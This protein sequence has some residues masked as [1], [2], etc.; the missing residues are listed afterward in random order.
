MTPTPAIDP[1]REALR[2]GI[3]LFNRGEYY[4]AHEVLEGPWRLAK[5]AERDLY[6]GLIK[7]AAALHH[8]SRE[9]WRSAFLLLRRAIIQLGPHEARTAPVPLGEV[10]PTMESNLEALERCD[11]GEGTFDLASVDPL[12]DVRA[13]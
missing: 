7:Y 1:G 8:A 4:E 6:Q 9:K 12:P 2:H 3:E 5:G 10:L 11:R 13:E